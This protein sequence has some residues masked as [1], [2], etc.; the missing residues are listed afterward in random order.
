M[1]DSA[2]QLVDRGIRFNPIATAAVVGFALR[3]SWLEGS[4]LIQCVLARDRLLKRHRSL[5]APAH[6][7]KREW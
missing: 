7:E 2:R 5:F 6:D 1:S 3:Q 4:A